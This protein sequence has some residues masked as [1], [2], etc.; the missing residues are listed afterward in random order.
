MEGVLF[1]FIPHL[2]PNEMKEEKIKRLGN[3]EIAQKYIPY[4]LMYI[5]LFQVLAKCYIML[6]WTLISSPLNRETLDYF[7]LIKF[8][9]LYS[10]NILR[11]VAHLYN[12]FGDFIEGI[13]LRQHERCL[14]RSHSDKMHNFL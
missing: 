12:Q 11:N 10:V 6:L 3:L 13:L 7:F 5:D 4:G 9:D 2:L 1:L 14:L 8:K